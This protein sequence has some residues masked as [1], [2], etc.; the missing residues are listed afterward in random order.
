MHNHLIHHGLKGLLLPTLSARIAASLAPHVTDVFGLM[1][2]GNA[3]FI[4]ALAPAG[5]N[6]TAVRHEV[7]TVAAADAYFRVSGRLAVATT[8]FG[9]GFTNTL[10]SLAEA[11]Q[12]HIPVV[13]VIG[14]EPS[15]G[16]RPW[17]VAQR[18]LAS[19]V[20]ATTITVDKDRVEESTIEAL[21]YALDQQ[22]AVVLAIPYDQASLEVSEK[23]VPPLQV[24][25]PRPPE[26]EVIDELVTQLMNA[27]KPVI[28]AGRG[29]WLSGAGNALGDL[30]SALGA[31]TATTT[32]ARS[33]FPDPQFD[34]GVAGGFGQERAMGVLHE[35]DLVLVV[36]ASLNQFTMRFGELFVEKTS[37]IQIDTAPIATN[38]RVNKFVSGD[39]ML[40]VTSILNGL[41]SRVAQPSGWRESITAFTDGSLRVRDL[42]EGICA[43]GFLDPRSIAARLAEI[44]PDERIVVSD[45]GHF[46]GWANTHWSV[47]APDRHAMVGTA[48]QT[49]GLGI[50][51]AVGASIARPESTVVLSTGDGGALMALADLETCI[52]VAGRTV[53]I[54]WN[55]S[56]YAAELHLYG[57]MGLDMAAMTMPEIDFAAMARAL[58]AD[59]AI[60]REL[61]D[62]DALA[63]WL[64]AHETGTFL[65]D[66]R[67]SRSVI[68]PYQLEIVAVNQRRNAI[69]RKI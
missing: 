29:A 33:I 55:D 45:G 47:A 17:A 37:V 10:T 58:G 6:F 59:S 19:A 62:L 4:D 32:L 54:V 24:A 63:Q 8:T 43:D 9:P 21:Q 26:P 5:L 69:G 44:L 48:Y 61:G 23:L 50:P 60:V 57:I 25:R 28:I 67:I 27:R 35:A 51:S 34:L 52:R 64:N 42:G 7:A 40:S 16:P 14:D 2:N 15:T 18:E 38:P 13:L 11:V 31:V 68:A 49:I 20:G 22:T 56:A 1:G 46:I 36:G 39:A 65:V 53:V 66:C 30:A 41:Q 3:Y 12:A